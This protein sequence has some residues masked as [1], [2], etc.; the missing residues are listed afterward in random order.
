MSVLSSYLQLSPYGSAAFYQTFLTGGSLQP[1][2]FALSGPVFQ[3]LRQLSSYGPPSDA[4]RCQPVPQQFVDGS[5]LM[6]IAHDAAL[7]KVSHPPS[8]CPDPKVV[9]HDNFARCPRRAPVLSQA[10]LVLD[11]DTGLPRRVCA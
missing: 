3:T 9:T 11:V 7:F 10:V 8:C 4:T 6:T 2:A 5:C 1:G